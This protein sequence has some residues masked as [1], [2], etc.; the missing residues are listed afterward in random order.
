MNCNEF[1]H[2]L[3][4]REPGDLTASETV[5]VRT[6]LAECRECAERSSA[7]RQVLAFR[8]EVPP[9]P[10]SLYDKAAELEDA[11]T[12]G[13]G[14]RRLRRPLILGSLFVLGATGAMLAGLPWNGGT[15][16]VTD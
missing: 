15:A 4:E 16:E 10:A 9:L 1:D 12:P 5:E 13:A 2:Y 14:S 11:C 3:D 7:V 6:H 8:T